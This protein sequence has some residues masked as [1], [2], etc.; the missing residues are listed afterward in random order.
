MAEKRALNPSGASSACEHRHVGRQRRVE[1]LGRRRGGR[2]ARHLDARDLPGRV[3]AGVGAPGDGEA[4]PAARIDRVERLAER[5]LDRSLAGLPR[6]AVE[7]ATV[8]L[9]RQLEQRHGRWFYHALTV[10]GAGSTSSTRPSTALTTTGAPGSIG[11]VGA[12]APDLA[13][14]PDL[15]RGARGAGI[16]AAERDAG[17]A[18]D[19]LGPDRHRR[20]PAPAPRPPEERPRLGDVDRSRRRSRSRRSTARRGT[21]A[22]SRA[23]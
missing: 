13:L 14:D 3:H 21:G 7:R 9:E 11:S 20:E 17:A 10:A 4:V 18:D 1:R 8:V 22:R 5:A 19:R 16:E 2:A 6:P 23:R 12:R 15:A